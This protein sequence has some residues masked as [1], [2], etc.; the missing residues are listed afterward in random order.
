[1]ISDTGRAPT[2]VGT[3]LRDGNALGRT[4]VVVPTRF[5]R[6]LH[7]LLSEI[8]RQMK[9]VLGHTELVVLS[10]G[11]GTPLQITTTQ[12]LRHEHVSATGLAT[13]RNHALQL[14]RDFDRLIFIDDDEVPGPGWLAGLISA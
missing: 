3:E 1:M 4:L 11:D 14:A 6:P 12:T 5:S 7:G 10:N 13:V 8:Q 2:T 9:G